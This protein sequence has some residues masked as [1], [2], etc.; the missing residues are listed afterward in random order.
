MT[1]SNI[2][3]RGFIGAVTFGAVAGLLAMPLLAATDETFVQQAAIT[4]STAA[5]LTSFDISWF[6]PS[7]GQYFLADRSHKAIDVIDAG[8]KGVTVLPGPFAGATG[9]NDTSGPNGLLTVNNQIWVGDGPHDHSVSLAPAASGACAASLL[10]TDPTQCSTVK[11]FDLSGTL[12]HNIP[13]FGQLRADEMCYDPVDNLI[14]VANDAEADVGN[15][16]FVSFIPTTG[17]KAYTVVGKILIPEATNGIEQCQ[18]VPQ[19]KFI[20]LN[21]PEVSGP[22]NDTVDGNV[23]VINPK[24]MK[25][26]RKIDVPVS[27]CAGP[28]GLAVGPK[29][30]LLLGCNAPTNP[31]GSLNVATIDQNSGKIDTVFPGL[32]GADEVWFNPGDG[33]YFVASGSNTPNQTLGIIDSGNQT[34]DATVTVGTASSKNRAHSVAADPAQNQAYLPVPGVGNGFTS[35]LCAFGLT[36]PTAIAAAE[37]LGCVAIFGPQGGSDQPVLVRR[38]N[39]NS[40][41]E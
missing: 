13:T 32:G 18:F 19:A 27:Q 25:V 31:G 2:N 38:N 35:S 37:A 12:L 20:Y 22:G 40:A 23:Y 24:N 7:L 28:Q 36:D 11:V 26:V 41:A 30:T 10:T 34:A 39:K 5:P 9:N 33:H 8:T 17:P 16:P 4:V 21:I 1:K 3:I 6:D 29:K 14:M 15:A